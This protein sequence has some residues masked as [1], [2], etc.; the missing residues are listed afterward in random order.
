MIR[1][2]RV[3]AVAGVVGL[4]LLVSPPAAVRGDPVASNA[5]PAYPLNHTFDADV[6]A[7]GSAPAN[8]DFE[9]AAYTV[10]TNATNYDLQSPSRSED[11][12]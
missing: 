2:L 5:D 10:G 12:G 11:T 6:L 3:S 8:S 9:A 1:A 4:L 7:V